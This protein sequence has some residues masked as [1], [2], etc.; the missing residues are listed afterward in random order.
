MA[1]KVLITGVSGL[2]GGLLTKHLQA[3][4]GYE[5]TALNRRDVPGV[6]TVQADITDLDTIKPAFEGQDSVVHLSAVLTAATWDNLLSVNVSGT[7]NVFEAARLAGVRR[8]V[9]A[10]SGATIKGWE[11]ELPYRDIIQ[12]NI[13]KAPA[14]W[15]MIG[16]Q[17]V[18]PRGFYGASKVCGEA[19][20]RIFADQYGLSI[21]C[22]RIGTVPVSNKPESS[23]ER[24]T[25]LSHGD[26][27]DILHKALEISGEI[28]FDIV[29]ATS[30]NKWGYRD[31]THARNVLGFVPKDSSDQFAD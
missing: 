30:D 26:V 9:F 17:H 1:K 11:D 21:I 27:T 2:I 4:G 7:Y 23:M 3:I 19:I 12:E 15:P 10:S 20:A 28:G 13:D 18:R 6:K 5:I 31:Q 16:H 29:M 8:V 25:Y 24:S 22:V 14:T